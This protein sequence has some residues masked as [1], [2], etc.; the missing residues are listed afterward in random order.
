MSLLVFLFVKIECVFHDLIPSRTS[1]SPL[2]VILFFYPTSFLLF[3]FFCS[4][5]LH[6]EVCLD[7][8]EKRYIYIYIYGKEFSVHKKFYGI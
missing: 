5:V 6:K 8:P 7:L 2:L 1:V 3:G 4:L